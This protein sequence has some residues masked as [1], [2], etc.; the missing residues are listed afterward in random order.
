MR[1]LLRS[2]FFALLVAALGAACSGTATSS[3]RA[4]L[5][6]AGCGEAPA[7][8]E[9]TLEPGQVSLFGEIHGTMEA[10]RFV[11]QLACLAA[12][13][14]QRVVVGLEI[15]DRLQPAVDR[16]VRAGGG[17]ADRAELL[18]A[19]HWQSTDGRGSVAMV[20]L[21]D[22]LHDLA[23]HGADVKVHLFDGKPT[24]GVS[25]DQTMG[26]NLAAEIAAEPRAVVLVLTGNLHSRTSEP[27]WMGSGLRQKFPTLRSYDFASAGGAA[28]GC[29][30]L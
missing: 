1:L 7:G 27:R 29:S 16:Y 13:R 23:A 11:G 6:A 14:G 21:L 19:E 18:R 12:A 4:G 2:G 24:E 5:T 28:W 15:G 20:A 17:A 30:G 22:R 25:R 10:P 8:I 9:G 26:E 3:P